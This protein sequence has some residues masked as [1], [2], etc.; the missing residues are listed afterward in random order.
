MLAWAAG[1]PVREHAV[2]L[3]ALVP[4]AGRAAVA[5]HHSAAMLHRLPLL[6]APPSTVT[7]TFPP[8]SRRERSWPQDVIFRT[9]ELP[10]DHVTRLYSVPVTTAARTVVDLARTM[11]FT[12][13]VM[14]ADAALKEEKTTKP[15]L[16]GVLDTCRGW[17]GVKQ[18]RQVVEFA[19]ERAESPLESA[20]RVVFDRSGL[21]P[22]ELQATV[23]G[24]GFAARA[25]FLWRE[26]KVIA[27]A[28]GL[29]K[30][31]NRKDLIAQLDRDRLLRDAG[32]R[33]VHFTW[34]ELFETPEVVL[35]RIRQAL[36]GK[37][38]W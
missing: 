36:A 3:L 1:N 7:L 24:P 20:A 15:E 13:G 32:Y 18:A 8:A 2:K 12:D 16:L 19:D 5:S 9:A 21:E 10:P 11:P 37:G 4:V 30:Y 29:A 28:D 33:V 6:Q 14:A 25:D 34:R 26:R 22:P 17:P 27:E 35:A 38:A 23:H 31:N